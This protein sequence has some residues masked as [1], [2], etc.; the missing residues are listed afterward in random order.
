MKNGMFVKNSIQPIQDAG[1]KMAEWPLYI[2]D[3]TRGEFDQ[4]IAKTRYMVRCL[5]VQAGFHDHASLLK[6]KDRKIPRI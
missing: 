3:D 2:L 6:Y 1:Y 4:I 5:G